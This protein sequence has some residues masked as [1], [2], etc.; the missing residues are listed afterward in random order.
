MVPNQVTRKKVSSIVC[1]S[2][3]THS[4]FVFF[5]IASAFGRRL[6]SAGRRFRG[7]GQ[8]GQGELQ[9]VPET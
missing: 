4:R 7:M 6:I 1:L 5:F 9:K 3:S 2:T 8:Y